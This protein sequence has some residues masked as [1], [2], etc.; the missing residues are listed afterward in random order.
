MDVDPFMQR[1]PI[2]TRS[3]RKNFFPDF[4]PLHAVHFAYVSTRINYVHC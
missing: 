1:T 4:M 3:V 2:Q